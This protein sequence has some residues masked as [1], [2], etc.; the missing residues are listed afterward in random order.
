VELDR[1]MA[2]GN[3]DDNPL[4][5]TINGKLGDLSNCSGVPEESFVLDVQRG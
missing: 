3:F 4:S 5:A 1:R 2:D